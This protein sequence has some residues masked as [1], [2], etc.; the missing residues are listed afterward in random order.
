MDKYIDTIYP[1]DDNNKYPEK[2]YAYL[3]DRFVS[4]YKKPKL[5]DVGC[6]NGKAMEEFSK[7]G[8]VCFG[9][10]KRVK[11][12]TMKWSVDLETQRFHYISDNYFDVVFSKSVIEHVR[13]TDNIVKET[14]RVLKPGGIFVFL[15]P[16]WKSQHEHFWDDYTHVK[17]FTR[18]SLRDC[19]IINGFNR[20]QSEY[21]YQLPF[22]W[23]SK[24]LEIIPKIID[25][26][27]PNVLKWKDDEERN[28]KDRKLIRFSKEKM[29]LC[30][31]YK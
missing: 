20:V 13:N 18:K 3:F 27:V 4:Q 29:I 16:D 7:H 6:G 14:H 12:S 31:G 17:A 30:W 22:V 5:L 11:A 23:Q 19:M 1:R 15:T 10:D 24:Y 26:C 25:F 21:F 8:V 28:T 2:L 9:I